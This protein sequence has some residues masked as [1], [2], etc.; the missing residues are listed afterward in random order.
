[1]TPPSRVTVSIITP[2]Y[3]GARYVKDTLESAVSQTRPAL[4]VIVIDDGSTDDS[5]AI[6]ERVGPPVRVIRQTNHGES[7]ARNRGVE[8]ARGSHVLFLDADDL[9]APDALEHLCAALDDRPGAV[10]LMGCAWFTGTDPESPHTT[11]QFSHP[12]FFPDIIESNFAPPLCWLAPIEVVRKAGGFCETLHW[13]E[14]WDLWWRVGLDEPPLVC[15][16]YVGARYRQHPQSQLATVSAANRAR[17]HVALVTRL[18]SAFLERPDLLARCGTQM[19]WSAWTA[20]KRARTAG[21]PWDELSPLAQNLRALATSGPRTVTA[22][23]TGRLVRV[24][25]APA[26]M[27]L[28]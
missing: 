21:V 17:G 16:P 11:K 9:L 12:Q 26:A 20:L 6:A 18:S 13:F 1:M 25:G 5:A 24:V 2:C 27:G 7:Y 10:A 15:V 22:S 23:W 8:A 28:L 3:N 4:E 14:D 19:F